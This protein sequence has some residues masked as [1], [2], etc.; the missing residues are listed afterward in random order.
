MEHLFVLVQ[1]DLNG[2]VH[3][4]S[5]NNLID[6]ITKQKALLIGVDVEIAKALISN[7]EINGVVDRLEKYH[8]DRLCND[9]EEV[10]IIWL[11]KRD[12]VR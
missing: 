11:P 9:E 7:D 3:I 6:A 2:L 10:L 8:Q 4:E 5:T 12:K 1:R